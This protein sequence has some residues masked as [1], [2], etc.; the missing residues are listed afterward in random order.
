MRVS[1]RPISWRRRVAI[2]SAVVGALLL[3]GTR[4]AWSQQSPPKS[5]ANPEAIRLAPPDGLAAPSILGCQ[6]DLVWN[7][8]ALT[9]T[10]Y[11][12][13]RRQ[14]VAPFAVIASLPANS[15]SYT[16]LDVDPQT[17]YDYR[18]RATQNT[19][20]SLPSN[21]LPVTTATSAT[22]VITTT[23]IPTPR[24]QVGDVIEFSVTVTDAD[25]PNVSLTLLNPPP[26]LV[27][28][29]VID[30]PAPV[31]VTG[32]WLVNRFDGRGVRDL[33]FEAYD[34]CDVDARVQ[35]TAKV[36][37]EG[38]IDGARI[39]SADVTGDG[40]LD[41][42]GGASSATIGTVQ[43]VGQAYVWAGGSNP[44]AAPSAT[45]RVPGGLPGDALCTNQ[46]VQIADV[47][48]DG[49]PDVVIG[50]R[51]ADVNGVIDAGAIYVW[52]GG[53]AL[54]HLVPP[55]ATLSIPDATLF[56][57]L[58]T[59]SG[60]GI[61]FGDITGDGVLDIIAGSI[62]TDEGDIVDCGGVY[63]WAGGAGLVGDLSPTATLAVPGPVAGDA[64]GSA[65]G[66]GVRVVD[67]TGDGVL[68]IVTSSSFEDVAGVIDA[69]AVHV[70]AGGA[71]MS[72]NVLPTANLSVPGALDG[73]QSGG[74]SDLKIA[75]V[76]GDSL[77]DI[78][79][80]ASDADIGGVTDAGAVY[81][82]LGGPGLAGAVAPTATLTIPSAVADDELGRVSNGRGVE[83]VDVSGD[84]L[85][86]VVAVAQNADVDGVV[87]A[88]LVLV[89]N[90][91]PLL[92]GA[93]APS[94]TLTVA[95]ALTND[96]L[97]FVQSGQPLLFE[98][99]TGDAYR[100]LIVCAQEADSG[101]PN[102]GAIYVWA[103]GPAL[104]G[105]LSPTATLF[106]SG[107]A[108][109]DHLGHATGQGVQFFDVTGDG[110]YDVIAVARDA[111]ANA[112]VDSGAVFVWAGGSG[113]TGTPAP[114]AKLSVPGAVPFDLLGNVAGQGV[115]VADV[116]G[117]GM[118]DVIVGGNVVDVAGVPDVGAVY[119][120]NGGASLTGS[121]APTARMA[122]PGAVAADGMCQISGAGLQAV[123]VTGDGVLD[124]IT[125]SKTAD[126]GSPPLNIG[127]V[128]VVAGGPGLVGEVG[129]TA[130]LMHA[131]TVGGDQMTNTTA[132]QA[133]QLA[134]VTGDGL[135]DLFAG[136]AF[137]DIGG[138]VNCGAIFLWTGPIVASGTPTRTLAN[139]LANIDDRLGN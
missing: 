118:A 20:V 70:W 127:A 31:T 72:G 17:T 132:G 68:D 52:R 57:R 108:S 106:D 45:L 115:I 37:I 103:G 63:A 88:G 58:G 35:L 38:L 60:Q 40:V 34:S 98:E 135:P 138:V 2:S 97:G 81:V 74:G 1:K 16:D 27:F 82:Y 62:Q 47:T 67:V 69:G 25:T 49:T 14:G 104:T 110:R 136:A 133:V 134:D 28:D 99:L 94:A 13:E 76:S 73:D 116:S 6:V 8:H 123:D 77:V 112:V 107:A 19:K 9:E 91:G 10:G 114:H 15:E 80:T 89:W 36:W 23:L 53:P 113:L 83:L 137:A 101:A 120:W 65:A 102:G 26:G 41:V 109:G 122:V 5:G 131:A 43:V 29:P 32:R 139:P 78:V 117:D 56:D 125:G 3:G 111:D 59:A 30:V 90:G 85:F 64:L 4:F 39:L 128:Y 93:P 12:V 24:V 105:E 55:I 11:R 44:A 33:V 22:P 75:D 21:V 61:Q 66:Q 100:D 46:G 124:I 126:S 96:R 79:V 50:T 7:D 87:D 92:A 51:L 18:V 95:G 86:D 84:G 119:V 129:P 48:G 130:I 71:G 54:S 42:I 121:I